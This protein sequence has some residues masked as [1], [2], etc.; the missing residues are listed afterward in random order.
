MTENKPADEPVKDPFLA[1]LEAKKKA[2]GQGA[3]AHVDSKGK[4]VKQGADK[5][6]RMRQR[7]MGS[8]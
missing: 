2:A 8:S 7:R 5:A 4:S 1:A 6:R 3:Q